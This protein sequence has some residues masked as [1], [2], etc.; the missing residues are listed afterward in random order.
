MGGGRGELLH[1]EARAAAQAAARATEEEE[2]LE[3]YGQSFIDEIAKKPVS[4]NDWQTLAARAKVTI[5]SG[6]QME[7]AARWRSIMRSWH[8]ENWQKVLREQ[9][10]SAST[11][12]FNTR[13]YNKG[14]MSIL[15]NPK[16]A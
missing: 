9:V 14:R 16:L 7:E 6:E 4:W 1:A 2:L 8:G 11:A 12:A 5:R 13:Q 10:K 3:R 15:T